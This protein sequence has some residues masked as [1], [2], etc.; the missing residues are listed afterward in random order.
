MMGDEGMKKLL[1]RLNLV[2]VYI[3]LFWCMV[4]LKYTAK[5][6]NFVQIGKNRTLF[7]DNSAVPSKYNIK[8]LIIL[9]YLLR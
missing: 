2:L 8:T 6:V 3:V 9:R 5:A 4:Q 7:P 1:V